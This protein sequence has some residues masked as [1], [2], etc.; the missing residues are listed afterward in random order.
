M[1]GTIPSNSLTEFTELFASSG[2]ITL[3]EHGTSEGQVRISGDSLQTRKKQ[4][5]QTPQSSTFKKIFRQI[6]QFFRQI[7]IFEP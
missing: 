5:P 7:S 6:C 2:H 1:V 3:Y 4:T